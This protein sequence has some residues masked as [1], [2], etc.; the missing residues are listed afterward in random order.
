MFKNQ[1]ETPLTLKGGI[2]KCVLRKCFWL[3]PAKLYFK[4]GLFSVFTTFVI[5]ICNINTNKFTLFK[6][7]WAII[8]LGTNTHNIR[9][10]Y[11]KWINVQ[12]R[13]SA[14]DRNWNVFKW[15][16]D[17]QVPEITW[18]VLLFCI[19][20]LRSLSARVDTAHEL[21]VYIPNITWN[22]TRWQ[23]FWNGSCGACSVNLLL[24]VTFCF[25]CCSHS[26]VLL[27]LRLSITLS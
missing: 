11:R 17:L 2:Q 24:F 20:F 4:W 22:I 26:R 1:S 8:C 15:A 21:L 23:P 5:K 12:L 10:R 18:C 13:L 14:I 16:G 6:L 7:N 25:V 3:I 9:K 27:S 19:L